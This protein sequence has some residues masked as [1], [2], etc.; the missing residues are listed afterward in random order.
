[1]SHGKQIA[2]NAVWLMAATAAQKVIAFLTFTL[3][4]RVVGVEVT[5]QYFY[6][7]SVSSVFVILTDL[8][9]TPV[10]I[11]EMAQNEESGRV[12]F[13]KALRAKML[14]IPVAIAATL[15]Y[16]VWTTVLNPTD[17]GPDTMLLTAIAVAS[18][19]MS[20]DAVSL[21]WYGAIR[22]KRL[23]RYEALG[24][25]VGQC[26]SAV[27]SIAVALLK[28]GPVGL[29][30]GLLCGSLW[31]VLWSMMQSRRLGIAPSSGA[32]WGWKKL[33]YAALPF[34]LAGMFVKVYSYFDSLMLREFHG[35]V[36]V[37]Y[38]AVAY[39]VTYAFQFLPLTFV[40]AL[41]PGMSA[42]YASKER[43]ALQ[44]IL[45]GSMRLMMIVAVPITACLSAL[46]PRIVPFVYGKQYDGTI[47]PLMVL[48][49]VLI[50]IFLDFPVGSL[51]NATHRAGKKTTAMG[52]TMVMN[53]LANMLLV[54]DLGPVGAAWAGV[55][56][57]WMLFFIG[58]WYA[59]K[60][61]PG[62]KWFA[63]LF[64]RGVAAAW[65]IWL[66]VKFVP[67]RLPL[68]I[69]L[70]FAAALSLV[71]LFVLA[72]ISGEDVKMALRWMKKRGHPVDAVEEQTHE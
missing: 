31:N 52:V 51:L 60:D 59:R 39:K 56:S 23:L 69:H 41:Y 3:V 66:G 15:A 68:L 67:M 50:P 12:V 21:L 2:Q 37:G 58:V 24:M 44:N 9:L 30:F 49:W 55:V 35:D 64:V 54:P 53:V 36:A 48:P 33:F 63:S 62:A 26:V 45:A 8:G 40:A 25:F 14:L 38:Y 57:F 1:M 7:V 4:A 5:G 13:A 11:R 61:F 18:L 65:L 47:L 6:A 34:A 16:A 70:V 72:L 28:G 27:I 32:G 29:V 43:G 17:A 22:G 71:V 20:A 19:V 10:V 42:A 46:A